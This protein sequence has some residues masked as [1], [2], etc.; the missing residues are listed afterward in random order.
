MK[1]ETKGESTG[2]AGASAK[3]DDNVAAA[4]KAPVSLMS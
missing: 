1:P 3:N 2:E 4:S